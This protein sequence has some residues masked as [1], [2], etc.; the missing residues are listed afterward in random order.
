[1]KLPCV[2]SQAYAVLVGADADQIVR[3]DGVVAL[4]RTDGTCE[5]TLCLGYGPPTTCPCFI[6]TWTWEGS[7]L[8]TQLAVREDRFRERQP[9]G[10]RCLIAAPSFPRQWLGTIGRTTT[11][12]GP[13]KRLLATWNGLTD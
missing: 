4:F 6:G 3:S 1:M 2:G 12:V 11:K 9:E 5:I 10:R 7:V 13:P 8:A